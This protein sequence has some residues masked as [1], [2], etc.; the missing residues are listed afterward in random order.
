MTTVVF[1]HGTGVREPEYTQRF[2]QVERALKGYRPDI[3]VVPCLWGTHCGATLKA[4]GRSIPLY[5]TTRSFQSTED[6]NIVLWSQLYL[7]PLYELRL[8]AIQSGTSPEMVLGQLPPGER[9]D[10]RIRTYIPAGRAEIKLAESDGAD[11]FNQARRAVIESP[12][13]NELIAKPA[14][15]L[16]QF[17]H[18]LARAIIAMLMTFCEQEGRFSPLLTDAALRDELIELLSTDFGD[19]YT[20][21]SLGTY[22]VKT[23]FGMATMMGALNHV[24]RK[25]GAITDATY[26]FVGDIL[27]YQANGA[28][29]RHYIRQIIQQLPPEERVILLA[30]SLGGIACVDLLVSDPQPQVELLVTVG[31]QAPFLYE[32]NALHSLRFGQPLPE[33]FPRWLNIYDL[34]DFLS[35]IA[36][37]VFPVLKS[38]QVQDV[39][40]DSKQPFP[41]AHS[42]YWTNLQMWKEILARIV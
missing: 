23:L 17:Q 27:L 34:R 32:I 35:Y 8:L 21:R 41:R 24:Q 10:K 11:L 42:A 20:T 18:S 25:R 39:K 33:T 12:P 14:Q 5:D 28:E 7:D 19:G 31:S 4:D 6:D 15:P 38:D 29:I 1:V 3:H 16:D 40:V 36:A 37:D 9:L 30:H 2:T 13:Y 26:P 22:V